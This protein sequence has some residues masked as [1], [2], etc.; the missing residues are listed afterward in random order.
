MSRKLIVIT[1]SL[2]IGDL[3]DTLPIVKTDEGHLGV[4]GGKCWKRGLLY[5][6]LKP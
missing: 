1:S 6:E 5:R 3:L 2:V 4:D